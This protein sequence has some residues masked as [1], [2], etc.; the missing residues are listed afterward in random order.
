MSATSAS[1]TFRVISST[2][3]PNRVSAAVT[4]PSNPVSSI[5]SIASMSEVWREMTRPEVYSSWKAG[6][7]RWK[8]AKTRR[9]TSNSTS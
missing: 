3:T 9:R 6:L 4:S 1:F 8:C 7:S 5:S 2:V